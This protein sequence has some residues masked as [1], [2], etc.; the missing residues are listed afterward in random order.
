[1]SFWV[2]VD[3]CILIIATVGGEKHSMENHKFGKPFAKDLV[4]SGWKKKS[5][6]F[7]LPY[8]KSLYV[9]YFLDMMYIEKKNVFHSIIGTLLNVFGKSKDDINAMLDLIDM[10]IRSEL[11]PVKDGKR[12]FLPPTTHT[13]SRKEKKVLFQFF[14]E[15]KV[16][17][18]YSSNISNLVFMKDLKLKGSK[19]HD[20]HVLMDHLL[21]IGI[22][23]ILP[24]NVI[25]SIT[26]LCFFFRV[27]CSK[28]IDRESLRTLQ[29]ES[30]VTLC[31]FEMYFPPSFFDVVVHVTIH[32]VKETQMC[33]P[34]YMRWMYPTER[35]MKILTGYLK[36][37]SR[38][39][40]CIVEWYIVE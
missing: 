1:M 21:P 19:S 14:H 8:W 7:E 28:V 35:Y 33:G 29:R 39:E 20:C 13:L 11:A 17:E 18:G 31:E 27:I 30:S 4:K 36:N 3:S 26:K 6:F 40:G 24:E 38:P 34:A 12:T 32:L 37:Q 2:I 23:S 15:V 9:R 10:G 5:I 25:S 22:H 16:L